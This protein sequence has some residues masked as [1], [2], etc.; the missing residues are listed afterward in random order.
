LEPI[1]RLFKHQNEIDPDG[2]GVLDY[3][4][5]QNLIDAIYSALYPTGCD[6]LMKQ[7]T[8]ERLLKQIDPSGYG[9]LTYGQILFGLANVST[10]I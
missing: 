5:L 9:R 10:L 3:E 7:Q 1:N 8:F 4:G 2:D 6:S